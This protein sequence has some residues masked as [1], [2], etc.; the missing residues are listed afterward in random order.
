[1]GKEVLN[2]EKIRTME[3]RNLK[4]EYWKNGRYII[5]DEDSGEI[6]DDAQ[7]YGYKDKQRAFKAMWW[8]YNK[9]KEKK[10]NE[11]K[12]FNDWIKIETNKEILNKINNVI[13]IN[14]KEIARNET[15]ILEIIKEFEKEYSIELP[16]FVK[17]KLC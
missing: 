14:F 10:D 5:V 17:N 12:L 15:T 6:V 8:K 1:M 2:V 16:K 9:G 7:G 11:K 3:N 13:V 4:I